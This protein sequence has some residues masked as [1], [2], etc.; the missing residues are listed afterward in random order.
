MLF[1]VIIIIIIDLV[2]LIYVNTNLTIRPSSWLL[3]FSAVQFVWCWVGRCTGT[4]GV[5]MNVG[6]T[7]SFKYMSV[8]IQG[9]GCMCCVH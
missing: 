3:P 5:W 1:F 9:V 2:M 8:Y 7:D 6:L 4:G